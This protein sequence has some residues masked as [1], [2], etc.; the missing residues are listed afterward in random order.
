MKA[1]AACE[2]AKLRRVAARRAPKLRIKNTN[3]ETK[4]ENDIEIPEETEAAADKVATEDDNA[5]DDNVRMEEAAESGA[6]VFVE[7]DGAL[8]GLLRAGYDYATKV[9]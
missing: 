5:K 1:C 4:R 6:S 7:I 8:C 9:G 3:E 2:A